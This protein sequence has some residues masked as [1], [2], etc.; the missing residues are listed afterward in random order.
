M[1]IK[2]KKEMSKILLGEVED[3]MPLIVSQK[4]LDEDTV[5]LEVSDINEIELLV[6]DEIVYRGLDKQDTVNNL[7]ICLY[8]LYDEI[9]FQKS[10]T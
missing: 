1:V 3:I 4:E 2:L 10:N 7:G 9:L 8:N 5:E 6:N